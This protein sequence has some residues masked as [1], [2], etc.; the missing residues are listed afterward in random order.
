MK[1]E[2]VTFA[3][4]EKVILQSFT[5]ELPDAGVTA[6][7]GPS[8]CGKTTL[9]R[10]L[11]GLETPR[12][13]RVDTPGLARTV[14]LFQED[15]L[16]PRFTAAGQLRAVLP[17][18]ADPLPALAA[19]GLEREADTPVEALSGGMR[20]RVALARALAAAPGKRLLLLDEPF[21]G[22][23]ADNAKKI[24]SRFRALGIPIL[25]TAHDAESLA[26]TDTV[27]AFSGPP[28]RQE[29]QEGLQ[30]RAKKL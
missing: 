7:S 24:M 5:L 2:N 21:T 26:L 11:A 28:L 9:L 25:L 27:L 29:R 30:D 23:D 8:G 6:L 20:R 14:F 1:L 10:L 12:A 16:L 3:Y 22:V 18:G 13:G 15:R 19:V 4:G 17:R